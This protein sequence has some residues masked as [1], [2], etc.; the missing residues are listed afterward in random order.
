MKIAFLVGYFPSLSETFILNQITGLIDRGHS[1]DI[2]AYQPNNPVKIHPEFKTYNLEKDTYYY[3]NIPINYFSRIL[4]GFYLIK[5]HLTKSPHILFK[6]LNIFKYGKQAFSLRLLYA[7]IPFLAQNKHYD[8]I[9]CHFGMNGIQ[10]MMLRDLGVIDG[11]LCTVF[12]GYDLSGYLQKSGQHA[13]R[14]LFKKGELFLPISEYWKENMV[15]LG[16]DKKKICVH[17][18]G[19][20]CSRF[21]PIT[22]QTRIDEPV[23][24]ITIARLVEKKGIEYAIRAIAKLKDYRPKIEYLIIGDGP[25]KVPLENLVKKL[26]VSGIVT[27]LGWQNGDEIINTLSR[28]N[29]LVLPSITSSN[30]D[31]EGIPV[32]LMEAMA[33]GLPVISTY[34]SGIP[35]LIK[36]GVSGFLLDEGDVDGLAQKLME[37]VDNPKIWESLG[38]EG[39]KQV[40]NIYNI[41]I[42][43]DCLVNIYNELLKNSNN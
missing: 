5:A 17:H 36:D 40:E 20:D 27:F 31:R 6:T 7:S 16:C 12:H 11:K 19:I 33:M 22:Q 35:E 9:H 34:H 8:I 28:S 25:L 18:M 39:R 21:I 2:Y 26:E 37:F 1:V 29:L 10:G 30:G 13:Y 3:P 15:A 43:N 32:V 24:F 4:K 38:R 42:L 23:R 14:D 41:H